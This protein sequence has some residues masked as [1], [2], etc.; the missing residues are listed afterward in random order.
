MF[1]RLKALSLPG[2]RQVEIRVVGRLQ[3]IS[4]CSDCVP[5][6]PQE[7]TSIKTTWGLTG[8]RSSTTP[9]VCLSSLSHSQLIF[10]PPLDI[11]ISLA[12]PTH[13]SSPSF[14]YLSP[15][16]TPLNPFFYLKLFLPRLSLSLHLT[17]TLS[18]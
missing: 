16:P 13:P 7:A 3:V 4:W 14:P 2:W 10:I 17:H 8:S 12:V 5:R 11:S 9:Y 6:G 15:N 1:F 18:V